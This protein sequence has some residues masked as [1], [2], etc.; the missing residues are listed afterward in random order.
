MR[1][2]LLEMKMAAVHI[3]QKFRFKVCEE[4]EVITM[5]ILTQTLFRLKV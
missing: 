5:F 2:A 4:T 3:L 1:L